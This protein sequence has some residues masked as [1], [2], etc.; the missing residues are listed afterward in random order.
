MKI[1]KTDLR[2]KDLGT[3]PF[4][5]DTPPEHIQLHSVC[6]I[7]GKRGSGKSFFASNLMHWLDFDRILI[8]SPTYESNYA[9]FRRL[10][11]ARRRAYFTPDDS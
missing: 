4:A 3:K 6:V 5:I 2:F 8:I 9:Q 7:L 10:G 11:V 1:V